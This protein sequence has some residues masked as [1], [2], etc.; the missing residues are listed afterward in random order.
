MEVLQDMQRLDRRIMEIR[1]LR[2]LI[3]EKLDI[4]LNGD[5]GSYLNALANFHLLEKK[6]KNSKL[7]VSSEE[8]R[9]CG[10]KKGRRKSRNSI[11]SNMGERGR[12]NENRNSNSNGN[13]GSRDGGRAG[14]SA[15]SGG[16]SG[17]NGDDRDNRDNR[18]DR[19]SDDE[20]KGTPQS[21]DD[22]DNDKPK[23]AKN[24]KEG[25]ESEEEK[26]RGG[27]AAVEGASQLTEETYDYA[28]EVTQR[29]KLEQLKLSGGMQLIV[30]PEMVNAQMSTEEAQEK[31][32]NTDE[33][34]DI[35][36]M[37]NDNASS[38]RESSFE[39]SHI[40]ACLLENNL[41]VPRISPEEAQKIGKKI[42]SN[43]Y[44]ATSCEA[45][46]DE[47]YARGDTLG[48]SGIREGG[49][50]V[51]GIEEGDIEESGIEESGTMQKGGE[52]LPGSQLRRYKTEAINKC[53][54]RQQTKIKLNNVL[55]ELRFK[56]TH[57]IEYPK[58][59]DSEEQSLS[60]RDMNDGLNCMKTQEK[61]SHTNDQ[62]QGSFNDANG[63]DYTDF[64]KHYATRAGNFYRDVA[65]P[66]VEKMMNSQSQSFALKN[67]YR[68]GA[69]LSNLYDSYEFHRSLSTSMQN[70]DTK[71]EADDCNLTNY[72]TC[73]GDK[74]INKYFEEN[75]NCLTN[76]LAE[77]KKYIPTHLGYYE[78]FNY[79]KAL[80]TIRNY[81]CTN[82]KEYVQ[83]YD[84]V[85]GARAFVEENICGGGVARVT[86][87]V[88]LENMRKHVSL[89]NVRKHVNLENVRKH[90]NLENVRKHVNLENVRKHVNLESV[91][92]HVNL[93]NVRKHVNLENVKKHVNLAGLANRINIR[94]I[95]EHINVEH[96]KQRLRAEG[97]LNAQ[98]FGANYNILGEEYKNYVN[99]YIEE[100]KKSLHEQKEHYTQ[101][102]NCN[103]HLMNNKFVKL[104]AKNICN[105]GN[106]Y[107]RGKGKFHWNNHKRY[108]VFNHRRY[109]RLF[110]AC[111]KKRV[112]SVK[113][114]IK[115]NKE[116]F[117][118]YFKACTIDFNNDKDMESNDVSRSAASLFDYGNIE[119][120]SLEQGSSLNLSDMRL[121]SVFNTSG[122][123]SNL[124][125]A[126]SNGDSEMVGSLQG[127]SKE[128]EKRSN[129]D[130]GE[131]A[132]GDA[133]A[134]AYSD[135][136]DY[137]NVDDEE[138]NIPCF[139]QRGQR[140]RHLKGVLP[141][142]GGIESDIIYDQ[143]K[144][145]FFD[146][147]DNAYVHVKGNLYFNV[148]DRLF[149][150][151]EYPDDFS[152]ENV[153]KGLLQFGHF[154]VT[155][156]YAPC[157]LIMRLC[158]RFNAFMYNFLRV[159]KYNVFYA[160]R[161]NIVEIIIK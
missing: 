137:A 75:M 53:I 111:Y 128:G 14:G 115:V 93:E 144:N 47:Q 126:N 74:Q 19:D 117:D 39:D 41:G 84:C 114:K 43:P 131:D 116:F 158:T 118:H 157:K 66:K 73:S 95:T 45:E 65:K 9:S 50:G 29:K 124:Q 98:C 25:Q 28:G 87:H 51:N 89:E 92:K 54:Q 94:S 40:K 112:Q 97:L 129:G 76:P 119:I 36:N 151:I 34:N 123:A 159:H 96:L 8:L 37:I 138:V 33:D 62:Q 101:G 63:Q 109:V 82:A 161:E 104:A 150:E 24:K 113:K 42:V 149:Y 68:N 3:D 125:R 13:G 147:N 49:I 55:T 16:Y 142:S 100:V 121:P 88:N 105:L 103:A 72:L 30:T 27:E 69:D 60:G 18:D 79:S 21:D 17:G 26:E 135:T 155:E 67:P 127:N 140:L 81:D 152:Y 48:E 10:N 4:D 90:V 46:T 133:S 154:L 71:R 160:D 52:D 31:I 56:S 146:F 61:N 70:G 5:V 148:K 91:R 44:T 143:Q 11:S 153:R 132:Y 145:I 110:D 15:G 99:K 6:K 156:K 12:K 136:Y 35:I 107:P 57:Q 85:Q 38:I 7:V 86:E 141:D 58:G 130:T 134:D 108:I 64:V 122:S 1:N 120:N 20:E 106:V 83:N 23:K 102:A 32:A 80:D 59:E 77:M 22:Q 2:K 139:P 78:K